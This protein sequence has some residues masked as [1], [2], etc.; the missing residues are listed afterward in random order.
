M[1]MVRVTECGISKMGAGLDCSRM[2]ISGYSFDR[3][4]G[5]ASSTVDYSMNANQGSRN[6]LGFA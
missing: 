4:L 3:F 2:D 6:S 5:P 1:E